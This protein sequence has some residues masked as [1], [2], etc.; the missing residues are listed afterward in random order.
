SDALSDGLV[1][2]YYQIDDGNWNFLGTAAPVSTDTAANA[3][4]AVPAGALAEGS[5]VA[6]KLVAP[7]A[8][9]YGTSYFVSPSITNLKVSRVT[10]GTGDFSETS[11]GVDL[12]TEDDT[13]SAKTYTV[14]GLTAGQTVYFR[15]QA[16]QGSTA[17]PTAKSVWV[18]ATGTTTAYTAPGTPSGSD[19]T[20]NSMTVSWTAGDTTDF[21]KYV[22]EVSTSS[23][24]PAG[25]TTSYDVTGGATS[26][27]LTGLSA[28][29]TYYFRVKAVGTDSE[30][31][32]WS[33]TGNAKTDLY[34]GPTLLAANPVERH[35]FT[36]NWT[37]D[38][39]A[40]GGYQIEWTRCGGGAADTT[41]S[42]CDNGTLTV[43]GDSGWRYIR[44]AG[45]GYPKWAKGSA[46]QTVGHNMIVGVSPANPSPA[47][48]SP[49]MDFSTYSGGY[50][51]FSHWSRHATLY[52]P[53]AKVTLWYRTSADG[54]TWGAWTEGET[55][56][57]LTSGSTIV[58]EQL[59]IPAGAAG[60]AHV[61]IKLSTEHSL[62][63]GGG[64]A[65]IVVDGDSTYTGP[66]IKDITVHG[67]SSGTPD[68]DT[69]AEGRSGTINVAAGTTLKE[70]TGLA[71]G[72]PY[73]YHVRSVV[74]GSPTTYSDWSEGQVTTLAPLSPPEEV[75]AE[76]IRQNHMTVAWS[77][78]E[79]ADAGTLYKYEVSGCSPSSSPTVT[80]VSESP[81]NAEL[82]VDAEWTYIGGGTLVGA[83][84]VTVGGSSIAK[85]SEENF[86]ESTRECY[87]VWAGNKNSHPEH[88]LVLAGTNSPGLE[89]AEFST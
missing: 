31:S 10:K 8:H 4:F 61:Q 84:T 19:I 83:E 75:W 63:S 74:S 70:F 13:T 87:P 88:S 48:A 69:C 22:L 17:N 80:A 38:A 47:V 33:S 27:A 20:R 28:N 51:E 2:V 26:K 9:K 5:R 77:E 86:V 65:S 15:V 76:N 82:T 35:A 6:F 54:S 55:T 37:A 18:E 56:A 73:Y 43:G 3:A 62:P 39:A 7:N 81:T 30:E 68:Y 46:N 40:T 50:V 60:Q 29:T 79:G 24:F 57:N 59:P 23:S 32:A 34:S 49:D 72:T 16:L 52:A 64:N 25:S 12:K 14:T 21:S 71:A 45:S 36:A 41:V 44:P 85:L 1:V 89:S 78:A 58:T 66:M 42:T 67:T 11:A 53:D